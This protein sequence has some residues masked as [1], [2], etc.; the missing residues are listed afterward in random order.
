MNWHY[1]NNDQVVGPLSS[2]SMRELHACGLLTDNT[3]VRKN[4]DEIWARYDD[5]LKKEFVPMQLLVQPSTQQDPIKFHCPHCDKRISAEAADAGISTHCPSCE[6]KLVVPAGPP[7]EQTLLEIHGNSISSVDITSES[8]ETVS[9]TSKEVSEVRGSMRNKLSDLQNQIVSSGLPKEAYE[10]ARKKAVEIRDKVSASEAPKEAFDSMRI[11]ASEFRNKVARTPKYEFMKIKL[12]AGIADF[13]VSGFIVFAVVYFFDQLGKPEGFGSN[14]W[15]S[16]QVVIM[17]LLV[18]FYFAAAESSRS[19]ASIGKFLFGLKVTDLLG[20]KISFIQASIRIFI[21]VFPLIVIYQITENSA[22][23]FFFLLTIYLLLSLAV[24]LPSPKH[25]S[26]HDK[27]SRCLIERKCRENIPVNT[28]DNSND[29][30][31]AGTLASL[32]AGIG[33]PRLRYFAGGVALIIMVIGM[34]LFFKGEKSESANAS[35]KPPQSQSYA[36]PSS[37]M[38]MRCKG[39]GSS[40]VSCTQCRGSR[41]ISTPRGFEIV[42]PKCGGGGSVKIPCGGCRGSGKVAYSRE[43]LY[44]P[45][46]RNYDPNDPMGEYN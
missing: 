6:G 26:I 7:T 23:V 13:I 8:K 24:C 38:C 43:N 36:P 28:Y 37:M 21:F 29:Q 30:S 45:E 46:N 9:T 22:P 27:L 17:V 25:Q 31:S 40:V 19:Q 33:L 3:Q 32:I 1:K 2:E 34:T 14:K 11:Y 15:R 16:V 44:A 20:R 4:G 10:A 5:V 42:C 35:P 41:T 39:S 18:G 12:F